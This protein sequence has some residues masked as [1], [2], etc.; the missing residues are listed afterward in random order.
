MGSAVTSGARRP[1][2]AAGIICAETTFGALAAGALFVVAPTMQDVLKAW[3]TAS[4][5]PLLLKGRGDRGRIE[6]ETRVVVVRVV[7]RADRRPAG[8]SKA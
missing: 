1:G 7:Q 3:G 2:D 5:V 8:G 4:M 6:P